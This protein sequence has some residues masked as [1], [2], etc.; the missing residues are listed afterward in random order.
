[1]K[2]EGIKG[3]WRG[4]LPTLVGVTPT[5]AIQFSV[6]STSKE[7]FTTQF[8]VHDGTMLHLLC[9]TA[10]GTTAIFLT[11]PIWF[12]KTRLQLQTGRGGHHGA[13]AAP[14]C[15]FLEKRNEK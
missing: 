7:I 10:G 15:E 8:G 14:Q 5:R 9:A 11:A 12:V 13:A 1:M 3:L 2:A 6:Y 4:I